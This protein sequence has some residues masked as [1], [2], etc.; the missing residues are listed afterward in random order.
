LRLRRRHS[1]LF[2]TGEYTPL[3]TRGKSR[4]RVCAFVRTAAGNTALCVAPIKTAVL[5]GPEAQPPL[6]DEIWTDTRMVVP[7]EVRSRAFEN[8]FTGERLTLNQEV[9]VGD[10][11]RRLPV[12]LWWS[13]RGANGSVESNGDL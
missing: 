6:G 2:S 9:A 5:C 8:L 7:E 13:P 11:L 4:E 1:R 10:L 12:G 3:E